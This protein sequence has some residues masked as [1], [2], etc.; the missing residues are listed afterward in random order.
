MSNK[1]FIYTKDRHTLLNCTCCN[2]A[3]VRGSVS[4]VAHALHTS[5]WT[6][7]WILWPSSEVITVCTQHL[8][9]LDAVQ[10]SRPSKSKLL[11]LKG[12]HCPQHLQTSI[13]LRRVWMFTS[14]SFGPFSGSHLRYS[15]TVFVHLRL[16]ALTLY[17]S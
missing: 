6:Q 3:F 15:F 5:L 8:L 16:D 7:N 11:D 17:C 2:A 10:K 13:L 14:S 4:T 12:I 1:S 9:P